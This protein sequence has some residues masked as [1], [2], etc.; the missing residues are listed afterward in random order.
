MRLWEPSMKLLIAV[1]TCDR[2]KDRADAQRATWVPLVSGA[3]VR[4]FLARQTREPLPD[5]VFLDSCPDDY[6]S[7][8]LKV[9]LT[10]QWALAN[11]YTNAM[12]CDDDTYINPNLVISMPTQDYVGFLNATPPKPWCSGFCYH[13]SERAM[14]IVAE[15]EIPKDEWAE[16]RWVGGIL[17]DHGI[18][19]FWDKRFIL[20]LSRRGYWPANPNLRASIAI[21]DCRDDEPRQS[22]AQLA[23]LVGQAPVVPPPA[24]R[25]HSQ[26]CAPHKI[27]GCPH[28][29]R[30][31]T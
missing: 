4:F 30:P 5:E 21:C 9:K 18:H 19:P 22:Q 2:F 28:C 12:K 27:W 11:G 16:D 25:D 13:L 7:L 15:A 23:E 8:P 17:A 14:R 26:Q 24:P 3:D 29:Q 6:N 20:L 1:V 31:T 10:F